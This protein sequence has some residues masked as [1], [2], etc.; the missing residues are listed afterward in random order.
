MSSQRKER[1]P[2]ETSLEKLRSKTGL[3]ALIVTI[4][5][6]VFIA[7]LT[8]VLLGGGVNSDSTVAI[9]TA[10]FGII[11]TVATAYL[12]IKATANSAV[13]A[14][15]A[16]AGGSATSDEVAVA[17]YEASVKKSKVDRLNAEIDKREKEGEIPAKLAKELRDASVQ[18]EEAAR[19]RHPLSGGGKG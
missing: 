9:T 11:S 16:S 10:A 5:A 2:E 6:V 13:E 18:A 1:G 17:H 7:G 14:A 4:V 19:R 3:A 8:A 15:A 12:G